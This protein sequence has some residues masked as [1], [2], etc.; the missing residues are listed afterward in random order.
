[1]SKEPPYW[2]S[3]KGRVVRAIAIDGAKTWSEIR[4]Q[5]GLSTRSLQR[6]LAELFQLEALTK[7]GDGRDAVYRVSPML[8]KVYN[9]FFE[10]EQ[11]QTDSRQVKIT[12][13]EQRDL[14]NWIGQWMLG[15]SL[16]I[17]LQHHHF[18]LSGGKL[19]SFSEEL[20]GNANKQVLIVNPYVDQSGLSDAL[21]KASSGGKEV[22]LITQHPDGDKDEKGRKR[23]EKQHTILRDRGVRVV[24]NNRIHAKIMVVDKAVAVVSSLNF[25][26]LAGGGSSW[27]AG[28][29]TKEDNIVEEIVDSILLLMERPDSL[30]L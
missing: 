18:Y 29:A 30:E 13:S 22:I 28:L 1:M 12:E 14:V 11:T 20:I 10:R 9:E 26:S 15:A 2:G 7:R 16:K 5:T 3:W 19:T 27:E 6:V 17:D 4:N 23:K 21:W 8:Y 25:T 24:Y